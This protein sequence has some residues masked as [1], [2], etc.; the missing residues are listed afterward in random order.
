MEEKN[1]P[2]TDKD[3][4]PKDQQAHTREFS[5]DVSMLASVAYADGCMDG[6]RK[7]NVDFLVFFGIALVVMLVLGKIRE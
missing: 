1:E 4:F 6:Y 2:I 7:A 3:N 5:K